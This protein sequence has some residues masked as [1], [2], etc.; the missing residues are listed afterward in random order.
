MQQFYCEVCK[1]SCAGAQV[2]LKDKNL[3][4]F[5]KTPIVVE[6]E[7]LCFYSLSDWKKIV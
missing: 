7:T 6:Q 5:L 4:F 3:W 1:I 2:S